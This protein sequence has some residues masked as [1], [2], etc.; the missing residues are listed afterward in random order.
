MES[1]SYKSSATK[2]LNM[3]TVT[4]SPSAKRKHSKYHTSTTHENDT[5]LSTTSKCKKHCCKSQSIEG[6]C[7][8]YQIIKTITVFIIIQNACMKHMSWVIYYGDCILVYTST[9][10]ITSLCVTFYAFNLIL[11]VNDLIFITLAYVISH[12]L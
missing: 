12:L 5:Y 7:D 1:N 4:L 9:I 10:Y 2:E 8:Q 3:N 6:K 11:N